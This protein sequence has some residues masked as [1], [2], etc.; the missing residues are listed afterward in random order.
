[1]KEN[2]DKKELIRN[3]ALELGFEVCGFAKADKVNDNAISQYRDWLENGKNDCMEYATKY[4]DLRNDPRELFPG[5]KTIISTAINYYPTHIQ[6]KNA[7]QFS[8]YAYGLD[9]HI[10]IKEKLKALSGFI[11]E[12]WG[13][14]SRICVDTAPVMEKYWARQAGIG[15]IGRNNLLII[16]GKGSFFFLGELITSLE[17]EPDEPCTESC[18]D[19][20]KCVNSCPGG[21]LSDGKSLDARKCLSCQLIERR[22]ELP[23]WVAKAVNNRIYG[24]DECQLACPHNQNAHPSKISEFT[25]SKEFNELTIDTISTMNKTDFK[26]IFGKSA[27]SRVKLD[28]LLR[29]ANLL[30]K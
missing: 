20:M 17:L 23:S 21:A 19:C 3:K 6:D 13:V 9:Y 10:V 24:C 27:I 8:Y 30:K 28:G 2:R 1:M 7:P 12:N 26:R 15:M 11:L 29:N 25:P 22:G 16:P 5:A 14:E 18:G 4:Q